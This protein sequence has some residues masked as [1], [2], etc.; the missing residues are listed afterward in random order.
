MLYTVC[1]TGLQ[2]LNV[3][4]LHRL[5]SDNEIYLVNS[6]YAHIWFSFYTSLMNIFHN[7][8]CSFANIVL[9]LG[10]YKLLERLHILGVAWLHSNRVSTTGPSGTGESWS[11]PQVT[12]ESQ[13][14]LKE[15]KVK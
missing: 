4:H 1:F 14:K 12:P 6:N 2:A 8:M 3:N 10:I 15:I 9:H 11:A 7:M 5:E 13:G